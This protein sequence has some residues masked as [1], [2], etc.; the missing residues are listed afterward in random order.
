MARDE[1][2]YTVESVAALPRARQGAPGGAVAERKAVG[3]GEGIAGTAGPDRL[4]RTYAE[5]T[6]AN[7]P[8]ACQCLGASISGVDT[9]P[10]VLERG[11]TEADRSGEPRLIPVI[12]PVVT[13]VVH[14]A[15]MRPTA[16]GVIPTIDECPEPQRA[17]MAGPGAGPRLISNLSIEPS[18]WWERQCPSCNHSSTR[19]VAICPIDS[20]PL[21]R[22]EVSLPFLWIG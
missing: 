9:E 8:E 14:N 11:R 1:R 21:R 7:P 22:V 18:A 2:H 20:T 10:A 3:A 15:L 16:P 13:W 17:E 6:L 4:E 19:D 5:A 12:Y